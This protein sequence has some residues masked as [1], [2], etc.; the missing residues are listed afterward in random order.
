MS[1]KQMVPSILNTDFELIA[2]LDDYIS[3][4]W[5]SRYYMPGDFELCADISKLQYLQI[6]NYVMRK[7]DEAACI[8]EK[9]QIKRTEEGQEMVI[10]SGR[11]ILAILG[12]RVIS[13]QEQLTGNVIISIS[14]L[15]SQNV[16]NPAVASRQISNFLSGSSSQST[17]TIDAQYLG[18]NLLDTICSLCET[19]SIGIEGLILTNIFYMDLFD[20]ED[21]S[22]DQSDNEYVV[23]SDEYDN[24]LNCEY[25][26]DISTLAT[27]VL[28]G[29]E[30]EGINR[31][32]VWSAKDSQ[33]GINRFEKFLDA[34]EAVSNEGIITQE[35]YEKQLEGLGLAEITEYTTAFTGEVNFDGVNYGVDVKVGDIV[36]I[37]NKRWGMY[38]NSRIIEVIESVGE[39][40]AYTVVPTFGT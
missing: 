26:K 17:A 23:F 11:S 22:Y 1:F 3:F 32:M 15:I 18:E 28:V 9:L 7:D 6:G 2:E 19:F 37:E 8:I 21:R 14:K 35:T 24:L 5:T 25:V 29:G 31:T 34:S 33:S 30:G 16:T 13:T 27:D 36:S 40:G 38:I 4:I 10:A 12:R 39:D 20:G